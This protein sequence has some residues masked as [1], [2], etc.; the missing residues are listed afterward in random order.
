MWSISC[1]KIK[2]S[3][4][5]NSNWKCYPYDELKNTFQQSNIESDN[6]L[7]IISK[8]VLSQS[9]VALNYYKCSLIHTCTC[10]KYMC[11]CIIL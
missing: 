8:V 4:V 6:A 11:T 9:L 5:K 7:P 1:K 10:P 2:E 3:L